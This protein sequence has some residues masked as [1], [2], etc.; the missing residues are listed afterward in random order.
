ME[1][2]FS[3]NKEILTKLLLTFSLIFTTSSLYAEVPDSLKNKWMPTF[4][5]E[6][7]FNQVS[8]T[9]WVQGG[10]NTIS[11]TTKGDLQ[12]NRIGSEWSYKNS[13]K[14]T[15]GR[16]KNSSAGFRTTDND[17]YIEN[18]LVRE[19]GWAV[20]PFISNSIRTSVTT[21]YDYTVTPAVEKVDFFDPGY[22]TQTIGFTYD[23]YQNIVTRLGVGFQE[24]FTNNNRQY[25]DEENKVK[26]FKFETGIESVSDIN[27]KFD[28]GITLKSK[29][30]LFSRFQHLDVWDVLLNNSLTFHITKIFVVNLDYILIYQQS[31]S[32]HLQ[33]KEGLQL[34]IKY[35]F[36]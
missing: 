10:N 3:I 15:Y 32:L 25:S 18:V 33:T 12:V 28:D 29:V 19:L 4:T 24:I 13:I 35:Q 8:F 36:L 23:K 7:G 30:R 17:I 16:T 31:Q 9:N 11:W 26:V 6:L 1:N 22:V 14:I 34:G 27:Y 5:I 20:S 2:T 21:G